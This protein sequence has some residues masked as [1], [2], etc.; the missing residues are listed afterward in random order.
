MTALPQILSGALLSV[1]AF[2][3][4]AG[5]VGLLRFPDVHSRL[6]VLTK[7]DNIGLG[8]IVAG[9]IPLSDVWTAAKLMLIWGLVVFSAAI[10]S[11]LVAR[12][13]LPGARRRRRGPS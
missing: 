13:A 10:T 4:M 8:F 5:A 2:F 1:G 11:Q 12:V 3:F 6:H 9:L 7:A